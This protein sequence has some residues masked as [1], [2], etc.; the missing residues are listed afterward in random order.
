MHSGPPPHTSPPQ[1]HHT[2]PPCPAAGPLQALG[3]QSA[4]RPGLRY[5]QR[6][7]ASGLGS[8]TGPSPLSGPVGSPRRA[9]SLRLGP[10][11]SALRGRGEV[12]AALSQERMAAAVILSTACAPATAEASAWALDT[13][14][15]TPTQGSAAAAVALVVGPSPSPLQSMEKWRRPLSREFGP[16]GPEPGAW[17]PRCRGSCRLR[18]I[19]SALARPQEVQNW[20]SGHANA[21]FVRRILDRPSQ[22]SLCRQGKDQASES[23]KRSRAVRTGCSPRRDSSR[24]ARSPT[25]PPILRSRLVGKAPECHPLVTYPWPPPGR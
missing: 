25:L 13:S 17:R 3:P 1:H 16:S 9:P 8:S 7:Q 11:L 4:H 12:A 6:P 20:L 19:I 24:Q 15:Q 2:P 18:L 5:L 23:S 21:L 10:L 22:D 14:A